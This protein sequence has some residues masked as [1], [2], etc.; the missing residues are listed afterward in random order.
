MGNP[1]LHPSPCVMV[2][3]KDNGL[4]YWPAEGKGPVPFSLPKEEEAKL[5][6]KDEEALRKDGI[7]TATYPPWLVSRP[8]SKGSPLPFGPES[9][10]SEVCCGAMIKYWCVAQGTVA[11]FI[12][13]ETPLKSWDHACGVLCVIESGGS[14][15]DAYGKP[16][17]F[18]G[19]E[20]KVGKG[21]VCSAADASDKT[22]ERL[23]SSVANT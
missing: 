8:M 13:Y 14:S 15:T 3:V 22:K 4:K 11:G 21:I 5:K 10:P 23:L 19:R 1:R 17:R 20:F 9:P 12:Q 6:W 16:V 2:S 7:R 18:T